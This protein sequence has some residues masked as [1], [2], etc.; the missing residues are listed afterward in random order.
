MYESIKQKA[1]SKMLSGRGKWESILL[2][3]SAYTGRE[4]LGD[5]RPLWRMR[6]G[7]F[8][9]ERTGLLHAQDFSCVVSVMGMASREVL[10][11]RANV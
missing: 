7:R 9:F 2:R 3:E 11:L 6:T 1:E 4:V 10:W 5:S 8:F